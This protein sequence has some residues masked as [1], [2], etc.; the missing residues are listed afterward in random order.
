MGFPQRLD[1]Q[2]FPHESVGHGWDGGA[3]QSR[4]ERT[5]PTRPRG[6][7]LSDANLHR[8]IEMTVWPRSCYFDLSRCRP[9]K[10]VLR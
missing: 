7:V 1:L 4:V 3:R 8:V 2:C 9:T 5:M 6:C 10:E